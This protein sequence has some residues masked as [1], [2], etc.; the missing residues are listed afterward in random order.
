MRKMSNQSVSVEREKLAACMRCGICSRLL[1]DATTISE[2]MHHFCRKCIYKKITIEEED[3]CPV[4]GVSLGADPLEKL[5]PDHNLR[6]LRAKIFRSRRIQAQSTYIEPE[7]LSASHVRRKER[8]L[9]SLG[10]NAPQIR[11]GPG[12]TGKRMKLLT[13]RSN[14]IE[15]SSF[16]EKSNKKKDNNHKDLQKRSSSNEVLHKSS[17]EYSD[18]ERPV[19]NQLKYKE[20]NS[21]KPSDGQDDFWNSLNCLV[22][23]ANKTKPVSASIQSTA[24]DEALVQKIRMKDYRLKRNIEDDFHL[25]NLKRSHKLYS[26]KTPEVPVRIIRSTTASGDSDTKDGRNCPIWFQLVASENQSTDMPLPQIPTSYLR[27]KDGSMRVSYVRKYLTKKFNIDNED[28]IEI[29]CM[30]HPVS[31]TIQLTDVVNTWLLVTGTPKKFKVP[32]GSSAKD[33]IMVLTYSRRAPAPAQPPT[34]TLAF[35][36]L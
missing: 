12:L 9:S 15:S 8:S 28:E 27:I 29:T 26:K 2:C 34:S 18:D 3:G 22:E 11:S 24:D 17:N 23:V 6:E 21:V 7:P 13:R 19:S 20:D 10:A 16:L 32:V 14:H 4:C 1:R 31:P 33:F 30:G 35:L 36:H 5:R 25:T